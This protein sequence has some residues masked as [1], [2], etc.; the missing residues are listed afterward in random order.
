MYVITMYYLYNLNA[1]PLGANLP[2]LGSDISLLGMGSIAS[3]MGFTF[4][5]LEDACMET[6]AI[7]NR[8]R[9]WSVKENRQCPEAHDLSGSWFNVKVKVHTDSADIYLNNKL[10]IAKHKFGNHVITGGGILAGN[11]S[12]TKQSFHFRNLKIL[13]ESKYC[14]VAILHCST[15]TVVKI[16]YLDTVKYMQQ[17]IYNYTAM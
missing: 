14:D 11:V 10:I 1:S 7:V 9:D 5:R 3:F 17:A 4:F 15:D 6:G 12:N 2:L 13:A 16:L 8:S